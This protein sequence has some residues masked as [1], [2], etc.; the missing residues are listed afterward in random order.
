MKYLVGGKLQ[1]TNEINKLGLTNLACYLPLCIFQVSLIAFV[2]QFFILPS[3]AKP[4]L[5]GLVLFLVNPAT[6]PRPRPH[7]IP[8]HP[9]KFIFQHFSV[10]VDQ[11][12]PQELEDD[13]NGLTNG[14]RPYF[15]RK[16]KTT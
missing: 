3:L 11:V 6:H 15:F 8:T 2:F 14:R 7:P 10:N 5:D 13:L 16:W 12:S 1:L 4:Q 9:G